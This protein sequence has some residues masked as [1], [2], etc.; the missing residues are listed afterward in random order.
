V[1]PEPVSVAALVKDVESRAVAA[2]LELAAGKR[3]LEHAAGRARVAR[4]EGWVPEL[5]AGV[6]AERAEEGWGVGPAV[7]VEVPLF[8]QGQGETDG[9][10][11]E[12]RR[13][14]QLSSHTAIVVRAR[15]R[16]LASRLLT[17]ERGVHLYQQTVLPLRKRIVTESLL[18]YNAMQI[19]VFQLLAAKRDAIEAERMRLELLGEYWSV[20]NELERLL[21]GKLGPD[22]GSAARVSSSLPPRGGA[23]G[24]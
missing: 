9:A 23:G 22:V 17:A 8:Y 11:A 5:R 2:S 16:A 20:R 13:E 7:E 10:L 15:A 3:R 18:Q 12:L 14:R 21:S 1:L 4:V 24:H 19:G 6:S